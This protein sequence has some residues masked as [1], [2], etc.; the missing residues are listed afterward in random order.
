VAKTLQGKLN[1]YG[2]TSELSEGATAQGGGRTGVLKFAAGADEVQIQR[3][4]DSF[5]IPPTSVITG[6]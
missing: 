5:T 4:I 2:F 6:S 3:V 1:T